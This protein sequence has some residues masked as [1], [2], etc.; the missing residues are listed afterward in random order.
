MRRTGARIAQDWPREVLAGGGAIHGVFVVAGGCFCKGV[1]GR[2]EWG[3]PTVDWRAR[4]LSSEVGEAGG[5]GR[6]DRT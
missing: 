3:R 5:V 1:A 2:C 4:Y 6:E